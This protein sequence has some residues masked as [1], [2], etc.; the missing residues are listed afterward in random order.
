VTDIAGGN[1]APRPGSS[2]ELGSSSPGNPRCVQASGSRSPV[3]YLDNYPRSQ[4]RGTSSS[5]IGD[6]ITAAARL[7][8]RTP[9]AAPP[10]A[11]VTPGSGIVLTVSGDIAPTGDQCT[12]RLPFGCAYRTQ[13][14]IGET[15]AQLMYGQ[16]NRRLWPWSAR[17]SPSS[18]VRERC[19]SPGG[20][21]E[22]GAAQDGR[23]GPGQLLVVVEGE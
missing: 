14:R 11:A 2:R 20:Q 16:D 5:S 21:V 10:S 4:P 23:A 22:Q 8:G 15:A 13:P 9:A 19:T 3:Q 12:H 7:D 18:R 17:Q 6:L 1:P